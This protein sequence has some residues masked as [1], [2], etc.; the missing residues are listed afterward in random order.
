L[1]T[2]LLVPAN[3]YLFGH[4]LFP[5]GMV[6][7]GCMFALIG[8]VTIRY[9]RQILDDLAHRW[10]PE[11]GNGSGRENV[12][13]VGAGDAAEL[14]VRVLQSD[15]RGKIYRIIGMVDD[16]P[17]KR[18]T[19]IRGINVLGSTRRIPQLVRD[20]NVAALIFTINHMHPS[21]QEKLLQACRNTKARVVKVPDIVAT[22]YADLAEGPLLSGV[23]HLKA[24]DH[25]RKWRIM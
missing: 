15:P 22:L 13:M 25:N 12:I 2:V 18:G 3:K 16:D 5:S 23:R 9:R 19:R 7:L 4:Q 8:F 14:I 20:H 6:L 1:A 24:S 11:N 21:A 17:Q 10:V